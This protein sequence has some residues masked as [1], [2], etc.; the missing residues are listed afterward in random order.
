MVTVAYRRPTATKSPK[1]SFILLDWSCRESFH[2]LD[3]LAEQTVDRDDYEII[4]IEFYQR[5]AA[6]L[7][8]KLADYITRGRPAPIDL[9]TIIGMERSSYY[10]KHLM[11]NIG[12]VQSRGDILVICDSD[13]MFPPNFVETV[14][15]AFQE[16]PDSVIHFDEVRNA[17]EDFYPFN[18]P[19]FEELL[20]A[21]VINWRDG[22]TTGLWDMA[23]P[24]HTRNYGACF[25][26]GRADLIAIGGADEH[27]D[28]LGHVCGPY[29]LTFRLINKGLSEIWHDEVFLY[30]TWHPGSDGDFNYIGPHD[31]RHMSTTALAIRE[32]RRVM[33]L[34]ENA[35]IRG[36][37]EG[38][39]LDLSALVDPTYREAWTEEAVSRSPRFQLF[40]QNKAAPRLVM[41]LEDYNVV[42]FEGQ[43]YGI[44]QDLGPVN[45]EEENARQNPR[46]IRNAK[47]ENV[48][49]TIT[50]LVPEEP[51]IEP[52]STMPSM[53]KPN[54][55][56]VDASADHAFIVSAGALAIPTDPGIPAK[57]GASAIA[58]FVANAISQSRLTRDA[59]NRRLERIEVEYERRN[60]LL[61]QVQVASVQK[62]RLI[63]ALQDRVAE[64]ERE[65]EDLAREATHW[66]D[67][68]LQFRKHLELLPLLHRKEIAMDTGSGVL[69]L[70]TSEPGHFLFGPYLPLQ[71]GQY[72]L[73]ARYR[74]AWVL[75]PEEPILTIEIASGRNILAAQVL[76]TQAND[77]TRI[78]F[79][80]LPESAATA[81]KVEFRLSHH[82]NASLEI[83]EIQ[84]TATTTDTRKRDR[85][86]TPI[87][88]RLP[89]PLRLFHR[90]AG[91]A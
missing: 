11:Y 59:I 22:K 34:V 41:T 87:V 54:G 65:R 64:I 27:L 91:R 4:W 78:D 71:A 15:T 29:E 63:A 74:A 82:A 16:N 8:K 58:D 73:T 7:E 19:S 31:G 38:R 57:N 69:V 79:V 50:K 13:A 88:P 62:D 36:L 18:Y 30:H 49:E 35:T 48:K 72:T 5:R 9:W 75:R 39:G 32:T 24:L 47:L 77:F 53:A 40:K 80:V 1:V 85:L 21:G 25:C 23:D 26:A 81:D 45:L 68:V 51:A 28:Y 89:R 52:A 67:Q 6:E 86:R 61:K 76:S 3:Y 84:L 44:P 12:I 43:Y 10:H 70:P 56:A 20:G 2:S 46:I 90:D 83:R 66:R 33:P 42:A 55:G 17:R 60:Q 14:V 37:R